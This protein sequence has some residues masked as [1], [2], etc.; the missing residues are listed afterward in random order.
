M[1][2]I[3]KNHN[4]CMQLSKTLKQI[5]EN[6]GKTL[7]GDL[8]WF[9]SRFRCIVQRVGCSVSANPMVFFRFSFELKFVFPAA[10]GAQ[11]N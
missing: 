6:D 4:Y 7:S 10:R 3:D 2:E 1:T 8:N 5:D 11:T 9:S